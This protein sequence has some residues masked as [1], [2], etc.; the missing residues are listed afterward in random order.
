M[1]PVSRPGPK[2]LHSKLRSGLCGSS[3]GDSSEDKMQ[4][5]REMRRPEPEQQG[6]GQDAGTAERQEGRALESHRMRSVGRDGDSGRPLGAFPL[7]VTFNGVSPPLLLLPLTA[8]R[9]CLEVRY[10]CA[11]RG[12]LLRAV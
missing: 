1:L 12:S 5:Q 7:P 3:T 4:G 2:G 6:W 8:P 9:F 10:P 11:R